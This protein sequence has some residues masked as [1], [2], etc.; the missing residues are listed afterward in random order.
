MWNKSIQSL[1][2][3]SYFWGY[4]LACFPAGI[5]AG[6]LGGKRVLGYG[7]CVCSL[8]TLL[9]P[10]AAHFNYRALLVVRFIAGMG[11]VSW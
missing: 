10:L 11:Q 8:A 5:L 7:L 3:G 2:L 9:Y 1:V 4:T 6:K